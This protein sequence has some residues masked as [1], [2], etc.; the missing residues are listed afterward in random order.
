[1]RHSDARDTARCR[2]SCA[3]SPSKRRARRRGG[4]KRSSVC[5]I[6]RDGENKGNKL[7]R[8]EQAK[9]KAAIVIEYSDKN[10][11]TE[12]RGTECA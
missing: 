10:R 11:T 8:R 5:G 7:I 1:M 12:M 3:D 4:W 2:A 9:D 6:T